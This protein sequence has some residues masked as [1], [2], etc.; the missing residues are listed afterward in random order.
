MWTYAFDGGYQ[1]RDWCSDL[2]DDVYERIHRDH[3]VAD[4]VEATQTLKESGFKV[5]YHMMLGLPGCDETRD[6]EAFSKRFLKV[7]I[8]NRTYVESY[9]STCHVLRNRGMNRA[10]E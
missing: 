8:S 2:Y 9:V 4:V 10:T 3:S 6:L 1:G 7:Q 5:G